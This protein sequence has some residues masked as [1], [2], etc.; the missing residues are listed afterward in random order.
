MYS[1]QDIRSLARATSQGRRSR[2]LV[3]RTVIMLG[4]TSMLTDVSSEMVATVL[5]LYL[6][7]T[8]GFTPLQ[9]GVVDGY[10]RGAA[11]L[12]SLGGGL[13]ADRRRRHK[14]VATAGYGLSAICKLGYVAAGTSFAGL[15]AVV[16][17]DRIGKGIRTAPRDALISLSSR[18]EGLGLAF[19]VHR[20]LDTTGA[21][22]GPLL[23]FALLALSPE[24]YDAIFVVSFLIAAVGV[25]VL[26]LMVD[27]RDERVTSGEASVSWRD[28]V[29]LL[30]PG[31]FRGIL[32]AAGILGLVTISDAFLYLGLQRQADLDPTLFPLMF[33]ATSLAY[34]LLAVPVGVVA[35]RV[36][37]GRTFIAGHVVLLALYGSLL[38]PTGG[39]V[40]LVGYLVAF[41]A[42]YAASDGVLSALGA[43][44]LPQGV[45]ATGLA[46]LLTVTSLARLGGSVLFGAVWTFAGFESAVRV[47]AVGL[48]VG[49]VVAAVLLLRG[50][51]PGAPLAAAGAA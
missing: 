41:G 40:A 29:R 26:V 24:G 33:T 21:M 8:L 48:G 11:A 3:S 36:G 14:E 28:A 51:R 19:G 16:F 17:A 20:A 43:A 13:V 9:F 4:L 44:A 30:G 7:F 42:F 35:D 18:R 45:Q 5:P 32:V 34:M 50:G 22:L 15:G 12:V 27:R 46:L 47:F 10:Q 2:G 38:L 25:G 49:V 39:G 1:V 6:V 23:A 31:R 37:R